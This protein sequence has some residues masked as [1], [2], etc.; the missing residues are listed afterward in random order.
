MS[1][2]TYDVYNGC[3]GNLLS[4]PITKTVPNS[5]VEIS[6]IAQLNIKI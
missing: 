5:I 2:A 6:I 1:N 3:H 4:T